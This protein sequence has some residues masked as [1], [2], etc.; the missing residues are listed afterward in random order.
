[1]IIVLLIVTFIISGFSFF[2]RRDIMNP[3]FIFNFL[4]SIILLLFKLQ[5]FNTIEISNTTIG[6]LYCMI[7]SF[8]FGALVFSYALKNKNRKKE[9]KVRNTILNERLFIILAIISIVV[10]LIDEIG[11][12]IRLLSG[13]TF[14]QI[15]AVSNGK[16]TVEIVGT[17]KVIL[18]MF[19]VHPMSYMVSPVCAIQT[20]KNKK[21]KYFFINIIITLLSV[22]HHG[23]R[24]PIFLM[25]ISYLTV[26]MIGKR[27][28]NIKVKH[29]LKTKVTIILSVI[30][31]IF[32]IT[33]ISSS[34]GI[35]NIWLS[36]YAY[37]ICCIPLSSIYLESYIGQFVGK[38]GG[39]ISS[40]GIMYPLFS[41]FGFF[42][43]KSPQTYNNAKTVLSLIEDNYV[44]IGNYT[45][46]GTNC[47]MPAGV[48]PY[49]DGGYI[50]E[51]ILFFFLGLLICYAYNKCFT[52]KSDKDLAIYCMCVIGI[53]F[54]FIRLV[55]ASYSY[56]IGL[57][58]I[59]ILLYKPC[60][61]NSIED[62]N[63][64]I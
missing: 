38:T 22:V 17:F 46:T 20:L 5:L 41:I 11:I 49:I 10:M 12:I 31:F 19:I 45:S 21:K 55:L 29:K 59:I 23:G 30:A 63:E 36:F 52:N 56:T 28:S 15:M 61:N 25:I 57:L 44:R 62:K 58:I 37:L 35:D 40:N 26:Y 47:F 32:L 33:K 6:I 1:M 54:S 50:F 24:N 3:I 39:M 60:R 64:I 42:G 27:Q 18:Y 53:V 14:E 16:G 34:R 7:I 8:D 13:E 48:Y 9:N 51:I 2:L 4:W 43:I